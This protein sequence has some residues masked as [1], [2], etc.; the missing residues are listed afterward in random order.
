MTTATETVQQQPQVD[1]DASTDEAPNKKKKRKYS[2]GP[3]KLAQKAELGVS[4][5]MQRMA[6]AVEEGLG[7]WRDR[8]DGSSRKKRDGALRDALKNYGKAVTKFH[9]VGAKLPEDLTG[10]LPKLRLFG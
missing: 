4:K 7:V 2:K 10:R 6:R 8:R 5:G 3:M 9:K 1:A